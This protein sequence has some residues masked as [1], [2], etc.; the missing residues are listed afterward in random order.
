VIARLI[1]AELRH[2]PGRMTALVLG[3]AFGVSVMVV[4]LAVGEAMLDQARDAA[5]IGGGDVIVL[6]AGVS[7]EMLK[8]GGTATLFA[9]LDQARFIQ[10]QILESPRGRDEFGVLAASPILEGRLVRIGRAGREVHALASAEIPSRAAAVGAAPRLLAGRWTDNDA[11]RRWTDPSP[12][13][14]LHEIDAF[15]M[16][17][18][19]AVGDSTW[20][21]WHYFNVALDDDRWFYLAYTVRGRVGIDGEWDGQLL[22]T[23]RDPVA[24]YRS[25]TRDVPAATIRFDTLRADLV[26]DDGARVTQSSGRYRIEADVDGLWID[27][28][29]TPSHHRL[30]PPSELG[31]ADLVSGYVVPA[32][33]ASAEGRVCLPECEEVRQA[34][35]YH[36]HNW[37]VWR[38]VSWEWGT[39]SDEAISLLYGVVRGENTAEQGLFAYLADDRGVRGVFRPGPMDVTL[40]RRVVHGGTDL[41][42]P[43]HLRFEDAR[44]GLLVEISV[45][46]FQITDLERDRRRYFL[47]L[48]GTAEVRE[49]GQP[50]R[51]L[52]GFFETYIDPA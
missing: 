1:L 30:F 49:L 39:A 43:V 19:S 26:L 44:L 27:L 13:E 6:P 23:L 8:V 52:R 15:H 25:F 38:D 48:R 14:L 50:P 3:Y 31:G 18:G 37:G 40:T 22:L 47:Q 42:V 21:E 12:E 9:G 51:K 16:P 10:R 32:L 11:D 5:L 2:R 33:R 29:I 34:V 17:Y 24:G 35:A 45:E 28:R 7:P 36:D 20:A 4:L 46:S 41:D